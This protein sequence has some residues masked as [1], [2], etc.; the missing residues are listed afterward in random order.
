LAGS[1]RASFDD[2][3]DDLQPADAA[4]AA[5][6]AS[7]SV[8]T[9]RSLTASLSRTIPTEF[10]PTVIIGGRPQ[11]GYDDPAVR[12]EEQTASAA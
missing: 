9:R 2:D 12:A 1:G 5:T 11:D 3:E 7:T 10:R 8:P 4:V 6:T